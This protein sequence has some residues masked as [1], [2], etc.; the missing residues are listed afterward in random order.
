MPENGQF[1]KVVV[2][3]PDDGQESRQQPQV[4]DPLPPSSTCSE[5]D[6]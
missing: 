5:E 2:M 1:E 6:R 4:A 3:L